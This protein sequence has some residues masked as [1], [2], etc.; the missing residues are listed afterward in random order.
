M[1][2]VRRGAGRPLLLVHGLGGSHASWETIAPALSASA[3]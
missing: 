3:S 1:H 2:H